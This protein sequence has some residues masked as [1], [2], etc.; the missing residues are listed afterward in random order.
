MVLALCAA[1]AAAAA[2]T[3][4]SGRIG[5]EQ[6]SYAL[7]DLDVAA[8]A[9]GVAVLVIAGG[10]LAA[11]LGRPAGLEVAAIVST[12]IAL[13]V[14]TYIPITEI[15]ATA[16]PA[17]AVP[18]IGRRLAV[19]MD[20]GPGA[21][22]ALA[23]SGA[24]LV[25]AAP[26]L[27]AAAMRMGVGVLTRGIIPSGAVIALVVA[28]VSLPFLRHT[29]W[30]EAGAD[31]A[32]LTVTAAVAPYVGPITLAAEWMLVVGIALLLLG[33]W[34]PGALVCAAAGW[35]ANVA[36]ALTIGLA[37]LVTNLEAPTTHATS[38]AWLTFAGGLGAAGAAAVA[39]VSGERS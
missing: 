5:S 10:A 9:Y 33:M 17:E 6:A 19:G 23:A 15:A 14:G 11:L 30:I 7:I 28:A 39:L 26:R 18:G 13:L 3:W 31:G 12:A 37:D 1:L 38:A 8:I 34:E 36:A 20:A 29:P 21:W 2:L 4:G 27:R 25:C 35:L 32:L 22:F 16:L 24:I